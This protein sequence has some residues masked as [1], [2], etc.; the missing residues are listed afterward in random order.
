MAE[1]PSSGD[2][3]RILAGILGILL[4][5]LGLHRFVLGDALGGILRIVITFLT[6]GAGS[7]IGLV[8]GILYLV[9]TDE[10]F[11]RIYIQE[12]RSWF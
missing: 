3:K 11:D 8:E 4:G 6:C 2:N 7:L 9:K 1:T 5:G 12:K 10:E